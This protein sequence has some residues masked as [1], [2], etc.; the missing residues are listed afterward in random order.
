MMLNLKRNQN[1]KKHL[2]R[3]AGAL[4]E[5]DSQKGLADTSDKV[6]EYM[7]EIGSH[8]EFE[9]NYKPVNLHFTFGTFD[10]NHL[11]FEGEEIYLRSMGSGTNWLYCNVTLFLALHNYFA[12]LGDK[13]TI[14]SLLFL[15]Q[16]TQVNFPNFTRDDADTFDEK[17]YKEALQR[18]EK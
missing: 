17:K 11:T 3:A 18:T 2:K 13:C 1:A 7:T 15:D 5:Y 4:K 6:N 8:F 10:L 12:E 16:P 9:T 14:P